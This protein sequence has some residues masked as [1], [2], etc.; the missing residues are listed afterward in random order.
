[1]VSGKVLDS[2]PQ[3][4]FY[5]AI[6]VSFCKG[7]A[8]EFCIDLSLICSKVFCDTTHMTRDTFADGF[9]LFKTEQNNEHDKAQ[10]TEM[11]R[12]RKQQQQNHS[13]TSSKITWP[14]YTRSYSK[15]STE[16]YNVNGKSTADLIIFNKVNKSPL[17][18]FECQCK[19]RHAEVQTGVVRFVSHGLSTRADLD[20]KID[21]WRKF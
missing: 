2:F 14:F 16:N 19:A 6:N 11:N 9:K 8:K 13:A 20:I 12:K 17:V 10:K 15:S 4:S 3:I 5:P 21:V 18:M 7:L 1:M